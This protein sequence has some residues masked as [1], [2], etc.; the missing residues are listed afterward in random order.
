MAH[1]AINIQYQEAEINPYRTLQQD[2]DLWESSDLKNFQWAK[3]LVKDK[4]PTGVNWNGLGDT[5][6]E[7]CDSSSTMPVDKFIKDMEV[8]RPFDP[9]HLF[10]IIK[11]SG[12]VFSHV[13]AGA[14]DRAVRPDGSTNVWDHWHTALFAKLAGVSHLQASTYVHEQKTLEECRS[15]ERDLFDDKNAHSLRVGMEKVHEHQVLRMKNSDKAKTDPDVAISK[16]F[17]ELH[18]TATGKKT[19]YT[20]IDGL[21]KIKESRKMWQNHLM[22][23]SANA[24]RQLKNILRMWTEVFP[25]EKIDATLTEALTFGMI[26]F[27]DVDTLTVANWTKY[28]TAQKDAGNFTKMSDYGRS[29]NKMKHKSKQSL[30]L[31]LIYQWNEWVFNSPDVGGSKRPITTAKAVTAFN[32][33]MPEK[34]VN[35]V[36]KQAS[37]KQKVQCSECGHA[38]EEKITA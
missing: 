32:Q 11:N 13:K 4:N 19:S 15:E 31:F 29:A 21:M 35:S 24:D 18:I 3:D 37:G 8:Q 22:G 14:V 25:K 2:L 17:E 26:T 38:W 27:A 9:N 34:F 10:K 28:F 6:Q 16:I 23:S 12:G 7:F 20:R 30:A 1:T 5:W 36:W 33:V